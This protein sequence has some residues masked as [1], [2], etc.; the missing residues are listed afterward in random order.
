MKPTK[1]LLAQ[2]LV[3]QDRELEA[4]A[5]L[6]DDFAHLPHWPDRIAELRRA[7]ELARFWAAEIRS[8]PPC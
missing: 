6:A 1:A 7:A 3:E 8:E 4:V 2:L 5:T